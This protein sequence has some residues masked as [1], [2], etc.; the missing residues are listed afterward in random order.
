MLC[1]KY[2][3]VTIEPRLESPCI[4][5]ICVHYN[6]IGTWFLINLKKYLDLLHM[7]SFVSHISSCHC[8]W[9]ESKENIIFT[10]FQ[11]KGYPQL[12]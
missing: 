4:G 2:P 6:A 9:W 10:H 8:K 1:V 7:V 12:R 11:Q 3:E 5:A